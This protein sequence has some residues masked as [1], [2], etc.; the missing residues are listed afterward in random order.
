MKRRSFWCLAAVVLLLSFFTLVPSATT[1]P[2]DT[3]FD[4]AALLTDAEEAEI[5]RAIA[6]ARESTDCGFYF[7]TCDI[8]DVGYLGGRSFLGDA[9]LREHDL[10]VRSD[11]VILIVHRNHGVYY[12]DMFY[13]GDAPDKISD[14]EVNYILDHR[15]VYNNIKG[16][17]VKDGACAFFRLAAKGYGGRVGTSYVKIGVISFVIALVIG[18]IACGCIFARY[19][20]KM[21]SVDYPL[22]RFAKMDL[23]EQSDVFTGSFVTKRVIETSSGGGRGGSRGGGGGHAGGR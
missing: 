9:F 16:G 1:Y 3:V 10:S 5:K 14:K 18:L 15:D 2:D 7:A 19:K 21:R 17:A 13:Y 23:K 20:M 4:N 8:S 11:L 6:D 12:Y 22:D